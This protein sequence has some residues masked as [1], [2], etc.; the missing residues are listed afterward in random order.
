MLLQPER[1][2]LAQLVVTR[3]CNLTCGYCNEYDNVSRPAPLPDLIERVDHLARLGALIVT[4]TGGEPLLHPK[5]D[6]VVRRVTSH[7][8]VC[9]LN[10]NA[11]PITRR[12]VERLNAAK[13]FMLQVSIDNLRPNAVS[14]KSWS[15]VR[16]K[17]LILKEHARFGVTINAVLGSSPPDETRRLVEEVRALGFY[18]T[19]GLLHDDAGQIDSG[20]IG[21]D[22]PEFY[23][24]MRRLCRKSAF[25]LA[26]EG[27]ETRMLERGA[28]PYRCRAG[29]RYLYVDETGQVSYCS[30]RRGEPGL[31]LLE[32]GPED[33]WA[34]FNTRKGCEAG[35]TIACVRRASSFDEWRAQ[36]LAATA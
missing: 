22:L 17:L 12:W 24:E 27:W 29:A 30:Q 32:Y 35:C 11:Y 33:A 19:V 26:G 2:L 9:T 14:D 13:L 16:Q 36:P 10:S 31:P 20:L 8:M 21:E 7:A 4:L 18:M 5:L 1:P 23:A 34:A 25:H 15:K 28:D 3:R 6:E